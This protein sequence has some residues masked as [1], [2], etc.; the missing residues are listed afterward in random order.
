MPP[1]VRRPGRRAQQGPHR[2]LGGQNDPRPRRAASAVTAL[3]LALVVTGCAGAG[4][5]STSSRSDRLVMGTGAL[6]QT[7]DPV[8]ASDVQTD[9]T[10]TPVYDTLVGYDAQGVLTPAVATAWT[11]APDAASLELTLRSD[12]RFHDGTVLTA[13][14]VVYTLDRV[15]RLGIGIASVIA[16]YQSAR[17]LDDTHVSITLS[18]PNSAFLGAL[19]RVYLLN[20]ALVQAN[21]GGDDAQR[22]L[23]THEAGSGPFALDS[24]RAGQQIVFSAVSQTWRPLP[25]RPKTLVYRYIVEA[26]ARREELK[27]GTI[28]I[29]QGLTPADLTALDGVAGIETSEVPSPMQLYVFF[30]T[31]NGPTAD[32]R[33]REAIQL[34]YDYQG[35]V[36]TILAGRG[37]IAAGPLPSL[38]ACRANLPTSRQDI[39][40][41]KELLAQ[42]G[43]AGLNLTMYYQSTI[44]EH[45]K[46]ATLLQSNLRDIGVTLT[47]KSV[48]Y[49]EFVKALSSKGTAP[50]LGMLWDFP[51]YP[52]AAAML[53][54]VYDSKFAGTGSNYGMYANPRADELLARAL[55]QPSPTASCDLAKQA[56]EAI[57]ADHVSMNIASSRTVYA[58]RAG[59]AGFTAS[60]THILLDTAALTRTN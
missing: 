4:T 5:N 47:L 26:A 22:W 35:H 32:P 16:D 39:A 41:A 59:I 56:E 11:V 54:R 10:S 49:P 53:D 44:P 29:A 20:S 60:P 58:H 38:M 3:C 12:I 30:D 7:L 14:D 28:D 46:A 43:A 18:K 15:H 48:T 17:A 55:A 50:D 52:D 57:D 19:S 24:Y 6:P 2:H 21:A 34:A 25:G 23:A 45:A 37:Q 9:L 40:R 33:V 1:H 13:R 27:A 36:D 31:A 42:A 51:L 8:L